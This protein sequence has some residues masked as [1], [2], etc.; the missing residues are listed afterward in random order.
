MSEKEIV[1]LRDGR[2]CILVSKM[3]G[4][5]IVNPYAIYHAYSYDDSS[6]GE[7]EYEEP[8]GQLLQVDKVF[9]APPVE[10]LDEQCEAI[11]DTIDEQTARLANIQ[12]ELRTA[13]AKI[14]QIKSQKTDLGNMIIN[15]SEIRN[16]KRLVVWADKRIAPYILDKKNSL[17]LTISYSIEQWGQAEEKVWIY[18]SWSEE[19]RDFSGYSE[20]YDPAYGIKC[21]LTDD[22]IFAITIERQ[23]KKNFDISEIS[24]TD[25]KWLTPG[26]IEL[27]KQQ[28]FLNNIKS[29]E[30]ANKELISAQNKL[31]ALRAKTPKFKH[32]CDT[33]VFLEH[34]DD[35][36]IYYCPSEGII[37]AR[38]G[39]YE[40]Q[41]VAGYSGY[42]DKH[43]AI[44]RGMELAIK[45]GL[46]PDP[47]VS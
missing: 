31:A 37:A 47:A 35:Y 33:C 6:S 42:N 44:V 36:D 46:I 18:K 11:I 43:P 4:V 32:T 23:N 3:D 16:A 26:N 21:D 15:K 34:S 13:Q 20:Y 12:G 19:Y 41:C 39:D 2:K 9:A 28:I 30:N 29:F 1:Y 45:K 7:S 38:F 27:A 40:G 5:F 25:F 17:K 24:N 10:V 22:E 8:S 14:D